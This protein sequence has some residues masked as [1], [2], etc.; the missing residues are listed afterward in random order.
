MVTKLTLIDR[1]TRNMM[2]MLRNSRRHLR[3]LARMINNLM[4]FAH[5]APLW[6]VFT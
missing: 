5:P 4:R 6:L 3:L 1:Q 2:I